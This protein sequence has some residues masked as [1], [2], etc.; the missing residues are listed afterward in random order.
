MEKRLRHVIIGV[1]ADILK[2]HLPALALPTVEVVAA[3]DINI[4]KGEQQARELGC[5]FFEDYRQMLAEMKPDVAV[6]LTPPFLHASMTVNCLN[7]GCHVLVE[8]PMAIQVSEA[9]RMIEAARQNKRVLGV[10]FQQRFRPEISAAHKLLQKGELGKVQRVELTAVWTRPNSYYKTASWRA[11]WAG[12][13]GGILTNQAS[14]NLDLLCYLL[15]SPRHVIAWT[16]HTLHQIETEDTVH[17]MLEWSDGAL[18]S[19]HISTAEA[20]DAERIKIVGTRGSLEIGRGTLQVQ[21]LD[22]D[23]NEYAATCPDPYALPGR[24][25]V[26]VALGDEKADFVA[27]YRSFQQAIF[28]GGTDYCDG[29]QARAEL[30]LA[31]AMIYS[32]YTHAEVELPLDRQR[33]A[34][35]LEKLQQ[36]SSAV[37]GS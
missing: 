7:A 29:E 25:P 17:A 3:S 37:R 11:T 4:A 24:H 20:D 31:N 36:Q 33:Y 23:M 2:G 12:E 9:D 28:Q 26:S 32:Q 10:V 16:R 13:G 35:L 30:E 5:A 14:H 8:K 6:I 18:G 27:V 22:Q 19:I 21:M 1:G 34:A 15:G